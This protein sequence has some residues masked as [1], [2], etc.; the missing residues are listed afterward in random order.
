[1]FRDRRLPTP[2]PG[3]WASKRFR[4]K[5]RRIHMRIMR[6]GVYGKDERKRQAA[7]REVVRRIFPK[8]C[9]QCDRQG[10]KYATRR[11]IVKGKEVWALL[12]WCGKCA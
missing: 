11:V 3:C 7:K 4:A 12:R 1:M 6:E 5:Y 10:R 2:Y 8:K 9:Y